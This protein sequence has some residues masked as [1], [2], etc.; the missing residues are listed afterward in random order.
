MKS[1]G[2]IG[3][4][5]SLLNNPHKK[6]SILIIS[7]EKIQ[8]HTSSNI[9]LL[10]KVSPEFSQ[11]QLYIQKG[12]FR[13]PTSAKFYQQL[14]HTG[15]CSANL[16]RTFII[17]YWNK[18]LTQIFHG[19]TLQILSGWVMLP[20]IYSSAKSISFVMSKSGNF[21]L[22]FMVATQHLEILYSSPLVSKN[23]ILACPCPLPFVLDIAPVFG[24]GQ[25]SE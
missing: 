1:S 2:K 8:V 7:T 13:I 25:Y 15:T 23:S 4:T 20:E 14:Q 22:Y 9:N 17:A 21:S 6:S 3:H 12:L 18:F 24:L 11:E 5:I 16:Y 10:G 19:L